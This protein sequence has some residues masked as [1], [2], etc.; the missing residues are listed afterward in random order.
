M[1]F[2]LMRG[3]RPSLQIRKIHSLL[4]KRFGHCWLVM[5]NRHPRDSLLV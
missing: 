3:S 2:L 1:H 5:G 4:V